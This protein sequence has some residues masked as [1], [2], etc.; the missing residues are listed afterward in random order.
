MK[1]PRRN[2]PVS[3]SVGMI[4]RQG[5]PCFSAASSALA[6]LLLKGGSFLSPVTWLRRGL[7]AGDADSWASVA[8]R[9]ASAITSRGASHDGCLILRSSHQRG[10]S[11]A[12]S[13]T[14][15]MQLAHRVVPQDT[16]A[17][18]IALARPPNTSEE[19]SV[20]RQH[21]REAGFVQKMRS[22]E[23]TPALVNEV[24]A[25]QR[26]KK[27]LARIGAP[28]LYL[29]GRTAAALIGVPLGEISAVHPVRTSLVLIFEPRQPRIA[30]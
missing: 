9:S 3:A 15:F 19:F 11:R 1:C 26:A 24:A 22:Y 4:W 28:L 14:S 23:R 27:L 2:C 17:V 13:H 20:L 16:F 6:Y 8:V 12:G 30:P 29:I 10:T 25:Q 7:V 5:P 21:A 18:A